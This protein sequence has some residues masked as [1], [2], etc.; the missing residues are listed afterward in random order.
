MTQQQFPQTPMDPPVFYDPT[1]YGG[2]AG[3]NQ[4]TA[5]KAISTVVLLLAGMA[6]ILALLIL[7]P[8]AAIYLG[9][10]IGLY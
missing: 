7:A 2:G 3:R 1:P 4:I 10:A 9:G 8:M 5:G 6:A